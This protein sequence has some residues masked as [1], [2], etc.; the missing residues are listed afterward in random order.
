MNK[1]EALALG[2][3]AQKPKMV[4]ENKWYKIETIPL[5]YRITIKKS[6]EPIHPTFGI[7]RDYY[8]DATKPIDLAHEVARYEIE[9]H[10]KSRK[11][12]TFNPFKPRIPHPGRKISQK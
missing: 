1:K 7:D 12:P 4:F 10:F 9:C 5:N 11:N 8:S 2:R 6:L 3:E